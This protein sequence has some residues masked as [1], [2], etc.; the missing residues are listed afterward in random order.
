MT[1]V[2]EAVK[3]REPSCPVGGNEDCCNHYERHYKVTSENLNWTAL[4]PIVSTSGNL[5]DET[6]NTNSKEYMHLYLY[7]S[8]IYHSQDMEATQ[9]PINR[10]LDR[11]AMVHIYNEIL[12]SHKKNEILPFMIAWIDLTSIILS[13]ISQSKKDKYH[14]ISLTYG[15]KNKINKWNWNRLIDMYGPVAARREGS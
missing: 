9:V 2:G 4:W 8:I 10:W 1:S 13:E 12:I 6:W 14:M 15:I 5:S 3:K 11:K 7:R